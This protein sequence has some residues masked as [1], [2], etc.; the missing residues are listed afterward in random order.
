[1]KRKITIWCFKKVLKYLS[2]YR[3]MNIHSNSDE[4][5][6]KNNNCCYYLHRFIKDNKI[7]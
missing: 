2:S 1:M 3:V 4:E 5:W 7:K 6:H